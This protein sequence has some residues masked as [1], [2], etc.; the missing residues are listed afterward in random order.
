[1]RALRKLLGA[2]L[3]AGLCLM[4]AP[5]SAADRAGNVLAIDPV[6]LAEV[7]AWGTTLLGGAMLAIAIRRRRKGRSDIRVEAG[8][9]AGRGTHP[10]AIARRMHLSQDAVRGLLSTPTARR[11]AAEPGRNF[12]TRQQGALPPARAIS[13]ASRQSHYT[14]IA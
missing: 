9:L 7:T 3:V 14:A 8:M 11:P 12:R 5:S 1:M 10:A 6:A 13:I 2:A 4:L